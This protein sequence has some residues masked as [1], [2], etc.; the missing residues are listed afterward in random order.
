MLSTGHEDA[1]VL[2]SR[3]SCNFFSQ[4]GDGYT[5]HANYEDL[6]LS[7]LINKEVGNTPMT[8]AP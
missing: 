2:R 3:N 1:Q 4:D 6:F 5:W 8:D 7:E